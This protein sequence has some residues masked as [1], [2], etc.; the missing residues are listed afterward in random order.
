MKKSLKILLIFLDIFVIKHDKE[1]Y[2]IL[3]FENSSKFHSSKLNLRFLAAGK[4]ELT[5]VLL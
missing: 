4:T 3:P 2:I 5:E 1:Y